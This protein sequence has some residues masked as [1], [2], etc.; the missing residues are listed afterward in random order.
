MTAQT[1]IGTPKQATDIPLPRAAHPDQTAGALA[2]VPQWVMIAR[3]GAWLGHPTRPEIITPDHLHS[4]L[5]YFNQHY[6]AHRADLV[7]DYHHASVTAPALGGR[8]PAA[9]WITAMELRAGGA[10]LWGRALWTAEAANAIAQRQY[11]C[12]SPVLRFNSPNRVSGEPV[13]MTVHSVALTNTPFLTELE[14]LN[15]NPVSVTGGN[16]AT[17]AAGPGPGPDAQATHSSAEGGESMSVL[18]SLA[19]ALE[20][21]PEQVASELGLD[22]AVRRTAPPGAR[23]KEVAEA[24]MA[25]A[26]R[27]KELEAK[28]AEP[29]PPVSA[30][31][32]NAL[33]VTADAGETKVKAAVIRLK[34]PTASL[35][36][37]RRKLSLPDDAP[38]QEI[39]NAIGALQ[40]AG[41]RFEADE[42]VDAAIAA[43][44]IPPA[45]RD[46]YLRE[47]LNDLSAAQDVITTLPVL[48]EPQPRVSGVAGRAPGR[49]L[50]VAEEAVCRQLGLSAE[51][52]L[53]ATD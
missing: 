16:K 22:P 45:H 12:L 44:K 13:P 40:E 7:I 46:F 15:T 31:V 3:T 24:M 51:A 25:N 26:A 32:A 17:A 52:F 6:A 35:S 47:A 43:G 18:D 29:V 28:L 8:A 27:L 41:R 19:T 49:Q 39:L 11:R 1:A 4:A 9:G 53:N 48:I 38:D 14:S 21:E 2:R 33:G 36:A 20:K 34:A 42:L 5:D 30:E 23:D 10:E 37:V 50:D